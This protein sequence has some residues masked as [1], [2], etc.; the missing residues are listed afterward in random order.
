MTG[1]AEDLGAGV[2]RPADRAPPRGAAAQ[3]GRRHRDG[4]DIVDRRRAAIDA[5][6][7]GEWR[8]QPRLALLALQALEQRGL[9]AADIGAGAAMQVDVVVPARA[10]G[11]LA[12]QPGG[13]G[14][15]DRDLDVRGFVEEL[16][17]DVDVAGVG[18]HGEAGHQAVSI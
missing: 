18:A 11:I 7:G 4:L 8:L 5:D 14:L 2:L 13:I 3:D 12:D 16:A 6:R 1:D 15:V 10:A 17:A 9:L